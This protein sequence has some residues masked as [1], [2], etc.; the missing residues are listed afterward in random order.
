[1]PGRKLAD[2]L[3][4]EAR[5]RVPV[6]EPELAVVVGPDCKRQAQRPVLLRGH[7]GVGRYAPLYPAGS[8]VP[9]RAGRAACPPS[10]LLLLLGR[11][12]AGADAACFLIHSRSIPRLL[13]GRGSRAS[14][15]RC[16]LPGSSPS[17]AAVPRRVFISVYR[18]LLS[19]EPR[20][21]RVFVY[22]G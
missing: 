12:S 13:L 18:F 11:G 3:Q 22:S 21:R 14:A 1:M 7:R 16:A 10:L 6:P 2:R 9:G 15:L 5:A 8:A 19:L 4:V 17:S 20:R